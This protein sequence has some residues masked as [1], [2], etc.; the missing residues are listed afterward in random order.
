MNNERIP[1]LGFMKFVTTIE[2]STEW[3][4]LTMNN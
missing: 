4:N 2:L 3:P 1:D